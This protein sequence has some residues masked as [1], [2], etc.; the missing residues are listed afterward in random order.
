MF[1]AVKFRNANTLA[2]GQSVH[3]SKLDLCT[4]SIV[5]CV[6]LSCGKFLYIVGSGSVAPGC[7]LVSKDP[8]PPRINISARQTGA[9][10]PLK[11][12]RAKPTRAKYRQFFVKNLMKYLSGF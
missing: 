10:N 8:C 7:S 12:T 6:A 11:T 5:M 1:K 2:F 9:D 4:Y 3:S